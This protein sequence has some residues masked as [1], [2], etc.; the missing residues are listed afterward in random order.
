M[1]PAPP[2]RDNGQG[3]SE[4]AQR[5]GRPRGPVGWRGHV[6]NLTDFIVHWEREKAMERERER[7]RE[8]EFN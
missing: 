3:D 4:E 6:E 8:E 2:L 5:G 7:Y 1:Q